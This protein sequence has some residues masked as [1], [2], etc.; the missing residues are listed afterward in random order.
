MSGQHHVPTTLTPEAIACS[1]EDNNLCRCPEANS[2][3][4]VVQPLAYSLNR[5][6]PSVTVIVVCKLNWFIGNTNS[7]TELPYSLHQCSWKSVK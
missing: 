7:C 6:S 5:Q 4:P 2:S 1:V 3:P